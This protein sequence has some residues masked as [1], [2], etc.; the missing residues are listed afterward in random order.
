[1]H[2]RIK[3]DKRPQDVINVNINNPK[4]W[5]IFDSIKP[6]RA[7]A[8]DHVDKCPVGGQRRLHLLDIN[9]HDVF[10]WVY[11]EFTEGL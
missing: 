11:E 5:S 8:V 1:M 4:A 6:G 10:G 9:G 3:Q 2:V 7:F